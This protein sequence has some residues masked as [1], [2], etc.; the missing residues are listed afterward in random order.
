[1]NYLGWF[2]RSLRSLPRYDYFFFLLRLLLLFF[3]AAGVVAHSLRLFVAL[4]CDGSAGA[5]WCFG[6]PTSQPASFSA[7][8]PS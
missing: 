3:S 6:S 5:G 7:A 1:M 4:S 2:S 8:H